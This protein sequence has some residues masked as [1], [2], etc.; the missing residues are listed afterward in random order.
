MIFTPAVLKLHY[1]WFVLTQKLQLSLCNLAI[2][3]Q[4]F[5]HLCFTTSVLGCTRVYVV[6]SCEDFNQNLKTLTWQHEHQFAH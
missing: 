4:P 3:K 2:Y 1:S 6:I 5:R